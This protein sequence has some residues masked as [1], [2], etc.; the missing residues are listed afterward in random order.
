MKNIYVVRKAEKIWGVRL[1]RKLS[2][3][4]SKFIG[5]RGFLVFAS[6]NEVRLQQDAFSDNSTYI[7]ILW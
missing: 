4:L 2:L 1:L 5:K 3:T 6:V 7:G